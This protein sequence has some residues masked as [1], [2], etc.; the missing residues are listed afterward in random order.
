MSNTKPLPRQEKEHDKQ[1][2]EKL[3][4]G[5]AELRIKNRKPVTVSYATEAGGLSEAFPESTVVVCGVGDIY[6][7]GA[8]R[9]DEHIMRDQVENSP[10][11]PLMAIGKLCLD[12]KAIATP[13]PWM[14][15]AGAKKI[16]VQK[17][18]AI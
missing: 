16:K 1:V 9:E 13:D 17:E 10:R 3:R 6:K 2:I 18:Q 5:L 8:H 11:I 7:Q 4:E 15:P 12:R 14:F